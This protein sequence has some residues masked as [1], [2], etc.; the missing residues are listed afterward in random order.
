MIHT[1][2]E[3]WGDT[4][5]SEGLGV[6]LVEVSHW[7]QGG[8]LGQYARDKGE[9]G[10]LVGHGS[11]GDRNN[12]LSAVTRRDQQKCVLDARSTPSLPLPSLTLPLSLSLSLSL[13]GYLAWCC[14]WRVWA[15][16]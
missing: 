6:E 8:G 16:S 2:V 10:G 15:V 12:T 4:Y 13:R 14:E 11:E 9:T 3:G 5:S 1:V 7:R